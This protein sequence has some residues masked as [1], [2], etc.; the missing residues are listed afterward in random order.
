MS[1]VLPSAV[2]ETC[3]TQIAS[4]ASRHQHSRPIVGVFDSGIGGLTVLP[5]LHAPTQ[6]FDSYYLGDTAHFPYGEKTEAELV[7]LVL[8]DIAHL[9]TAGCSLIGIACNTASI[10]WNELVSQLPE[11]VK[12]QA[13]NYVLNT[14]STTMQALAQLD[15]RQT[16]GIIGTSFTVQ[17]GA[18]RRA[19]ERQF[20]SARP[21]ILQSAEQSLVNAIE[22]DDPAA[23]S[24]EL[25]RI[26][27]F[28][29]AYPLDVFILGCTHYGH[30]APAIKRALPPNVVMLDPSFLL[31][32]ALRSLAL[33]HF[34]PTSF[35]PTSFPP[36]ST[37]LPSKAGSAA[38]LAPASGSTPPTTSAPHYNSVI[39]F[40]GE[41]PTTSVY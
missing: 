27:H 40:T 17:S 9:V 6:I 36:T 7:P 34:S 25:A 22:H 41:T 35:P 15:R 26:M 13:N 5:A 3:A 10:V 23:I 39:T 31:G 30:I 29:S 12:H 2:I 24:Q 28:F 32:Q 1:V 37:T 38:L 11:P 14:I 16:I 8:A 33:A 19:I 18:Y 4:L 21:V 20:P